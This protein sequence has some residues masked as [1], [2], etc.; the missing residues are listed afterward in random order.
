MTLD[1]Q[2][3]T[4]LVQTAAD[5]V[6]V[7][8]ALVATLRATTALTRRLRRRRTRKARRRKGRM[9]EGRPRIRNRSNPGVRT[10]RFRHY[11]N[12]RTTCPAHWRR[13]DAPAA[14]KGRRAFR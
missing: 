12:Q 3:L 1:F 4:T 5:A 9:W 6:T 7:V 14:P 11:R 8:T 10:T 13:A 2:T